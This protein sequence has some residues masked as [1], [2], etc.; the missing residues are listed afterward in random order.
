MPNVLVKLHA[1]IRAIS[2]HFTGKSQQIIEIAL[3]YPHQ[4]II[5]CPVQGHG[6][7]IKMC[8]YPFRQDRLYPPPSASF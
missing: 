4:Y 1:K 3:P 6:S 7:P 8:D 5:L 2:L